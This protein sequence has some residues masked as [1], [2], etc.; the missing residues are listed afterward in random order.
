MYQLGSN[1]KL[2]EFVYV[3]SAAHAHILAAHALLANRPGA[4][5]QAYFITD[6]AAMPFFTF[7]R[8]A[9]AA[10]GFPVTEA[11]VKVT[12]LWVVQTIASLVE[13]LYWI[14]S[15]GTKSPQ[16]RRQ[17]I[18]HL[19]SGCYWSIDKAE[20]LLGYKPVLEQDEAVE[21]SMRWGMENC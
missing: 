16:M 9:C 6:G 14:G 8:K 13:W 1:T 4:A 19:D 2:F 18:D 7:C 15:L 21:R 17:E 20:K 5:G 11:D 3:G 12:P 10:A